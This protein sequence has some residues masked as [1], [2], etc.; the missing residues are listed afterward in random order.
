MP[1]AA[2]NVLG[3]IKVGTNLSIDGNGVL[4]ASQLT[5]TASAVNDLYGDNGNL[6][7]GTGS[8]DDTLKLYYDGTNAKITSVITQYIYSKMVRT[9]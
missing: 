2:S 3:G 5:L 8:G 7:L 1:T 4:S 9:N 6:I